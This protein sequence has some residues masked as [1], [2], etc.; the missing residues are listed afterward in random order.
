MEKMKC[1]NCSIE[2]TD[3]MNLQCSRAILEL[4]CSRDC[5]MDFYMKEMNNYKVDIKNIRDYIKFA[6]VSDGNIYH[7]DI[8]DDVCNNCEDGVFNFYK[9]EV[10]NGNRYEVYKCSECGKETKVACK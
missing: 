5:A 7:S 6:Y 9:F 2:L 8:E 4:F 10:I 3:K 1:H